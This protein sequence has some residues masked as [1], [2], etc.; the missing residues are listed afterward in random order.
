M[1]KRGQF[2]ST[3]EV[4]TVKR[5]YKSRTNSMIGGV[6][7]GIAEY[8]EI[9]PT[10]VRLGFALLGLFYGIGIVSYLILWIIA[11]YPDAG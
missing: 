9:D 10:I 6:C 8:L 5:L 7:G 2:Q 11:P 1:G 4:S 3:N